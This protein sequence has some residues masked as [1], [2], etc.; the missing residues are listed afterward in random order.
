MNEWDDIILQTRAKELKEII[1]IA[2]FELMA[3][4][5]ELTKRDQ[6][7]EAPITIRMPRKYETT[8]S[9]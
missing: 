9:L 7:K 8:V 3:I 1:K 2:N 4:D 5:R 6:V